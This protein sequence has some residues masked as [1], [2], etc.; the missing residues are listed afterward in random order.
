MRLL[1]QNILQSNIQSNNDSPS[2][3]IERKKIIL[4]NLLEERGKGALIRARYTQLNYMD[5]PTAFFFGLEKK[6]R[7]KKY[8]HHLKLSN[9]QQITD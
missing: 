6:F 7:D 4:K 1:E 9:G 2:A 3:D 8:F 5:A